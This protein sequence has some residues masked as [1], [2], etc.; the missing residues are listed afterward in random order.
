MTYWSQIV[1]L[2]F[3]AVTS[4]TDDSE[5]GWRLFRMMNEMLYIGSLG[6]NWLGVVW[7]QWERST[8]GLFNFT[9]SD[10]LVWLVLSLFYNVG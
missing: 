2:V 4:L 10:N 5:S 8:D 7:S 3:A 6:L 9:N 1:G